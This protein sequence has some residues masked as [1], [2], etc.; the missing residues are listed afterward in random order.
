MGIFRQTLL[1]AGVVAASLVALGPFSVGTGMA[2]DN[3]KIE[4]TVSVSATGSVA[5]EP[6]IAQISAGV[7]TEADTAKDAIGRNSAVMGKLIDGLKAAGVAA[8]DIQTKTLNVEPRYTQPKDGRA[9]T[10]NGY[11]VL[12]QV[13]LTVREV[14][15]LGEILDQAIALGANQINSIAFDVSNMEML[16][17][18]ARKLAMENARRRGELYAK[19]AGGQLGPV[20]RIAETIAGLQQPVFDGRMAMRANVPIEAGTRDLEVEIHVTY[21]LR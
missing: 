19:A 18:E 12:N 14:K 15:R 20:L 2:A 3:D 21:G 8:K 16:K 10:I 9:A 5:V 1:A 6:D 7:I 4:R 13:R 17:D 11:R